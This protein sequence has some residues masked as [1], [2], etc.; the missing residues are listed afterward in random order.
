MAGE[1]ANPAIFVMGDL[2][3]GPGKEPFEERYLYFDLISNVQGDV[4][5]ARR[6]LNHALFDFRESSGGARTSQTSY[7]RSAI[8]APSSI[9][10]SSRRDSSTVRCRGRSSHTL[11]R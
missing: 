8:P 11:A 9:T 3:D 10:P 2:N 7:N 1:D 6:F 5:W 4:F